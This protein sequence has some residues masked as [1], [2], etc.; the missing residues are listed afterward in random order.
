MASV[1]KVECINDNCGMPPEILIFT[2][3]YWVAEIIGKSDKYGYERRFLKYK[4]DYSEANSKGT[5]GVYAY[6]ILENEK[7]Y[8]VCSPQSWKND[9]RYFCI[10]I[11]DTQFRVPREE[12]DV[13]LKHTLK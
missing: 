10:I 6:Y 7:I 1:I 9:D 2:N 13:C 3:R 11:N 4:K 8:E 5:R 12:V